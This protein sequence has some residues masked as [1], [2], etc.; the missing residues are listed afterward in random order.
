MYLRTCLGLGN[1]MESNLETSNNVVNNLSYFKNKCIDIFTLINYSPIPLE[2]V[3]DFLIHSSFNNLSWS[4]NWGIDYYYVNDFFN[5][6]QKKITLVYMHETDHSFYRNVLQREKAEKWFKKFDEKCLEKVGRTFTQ[7]LN[8]CIANMP[9]NGTTNMLVYYLLAKIGPTYISKEN[10][11]RLFERMM[12]VDADSKFT[13]YKESGY[14]LFE[15]FLVIN[16][17]EYLKNYPEYFIPY[18]KN[19]ND[20]FGKYIRYSPDKFNIFSFAEIIKANDEMYEI[21]SNKHCQTAIFCKLVKE[22]NDLIIKYKED[23]NKLPIEEKELKKHIRTGKVDLLVKY[24][25]L[26]DNIS[27][28]REKKL[29]ELLLKYKKTFTLEKIHYVIDNYNCVYEEN[30]HILKKYLMICKLR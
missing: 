8:D 5:S 20:S 26:Q 24:L 22:T 9:L 2:D 21:F 28:E 4:R 23:I 10:I 17:I 18:L 1:F 30:S 3:Y 29:I 19:N 6:I 16:I 25:L 13:K 27:L 14:T 11:I 7:I 12:V 15:D